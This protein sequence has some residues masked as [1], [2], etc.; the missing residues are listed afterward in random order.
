MY[1]NRGSRDV[2]GRDESWWQSRT[3]L[4]QK[5]VILSTVLFILAFSLMISVIVIKNRSPAAPSA[6]TTVSPVTGTG[7]TTTGTEE[8]TPSTSPTPTVEPTPST[9]STVEPTPSTNSTVE[10]TPPTNT[11]VEPPPTS[12]AKNTTTTTTATT[13]TTTSEAPTTTAA[14]STGATPII[15]ELTE[16]NKPE[17]FAPGSIN[18]RPA[19]Y[20]SPRALANLNGA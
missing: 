15:P 2:M 17:A 6:T 13:T 7:D 11:T 5:L 9:N 18:N 8:P 19:R 16:E 10:P 12:P 3:G 1:S 14:S 20:I 4:E